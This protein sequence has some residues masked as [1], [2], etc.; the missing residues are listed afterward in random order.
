MIAILAS[1]VVVS[2]VRIARPIE[3]A[4]HV[5]WTLFALHGGYLLYECLI[6]RLVV[7]RLASGH[8]VPSPLWR[9]NAVAESLLPLLAMANGILLT[10]LDP[11]VVLLMPALPFIFVLLIMST[12]RIDPLQCALGGTVSTIGY[13]A[14]TALVFVRFPYA[15]HNAGAH[16]WSIFVFMI[17]MLALGTAVA[18]FVAWQ[19]RQ[20]VIAALHEAQVKREKEMMQ[21]D[22]AVAQSIQRHLLPSRLPNVTG[23]DVA[24]RSVPA[25]QTGGDYYDWQPLGDGRIVISLADVTGHGVGPALVTAACRAYVRAVLHPETSPKDVLD[26][27]NRLLARD[28]PGG[29]FVTFALLE[30]DPNRHRGVFLAAGHGPSFFVSGDRGE[31]TSVGA[32]GLPLA[33]LEEHV[34]EGPVEFEF[35]PGDLVALFSDGFFEW[36]DSAGRQFGEERLRSVVCE[37]R[38]GPAASIVSRMDE[39]VR[40]F[41]NGE[42]QPD[43]MTVV[44]IKRHPD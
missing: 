1:V 44:V 37:N 34:T 10:A 35:R 3:E 20:H 43:D 8:D 33:V 41:A 30:I 28:V 29:R 19:V 23:Y 18:T 13:A 21:A 40:T 38:H 7:H 22:L 2:I 14:L 36:P 4:P 32:Q 24:A 9:I 25:S 26:R 11:Y 15:Q 5:G 12:L 42:P 16:H 17:L 6:L 27:V 31:V 39:A